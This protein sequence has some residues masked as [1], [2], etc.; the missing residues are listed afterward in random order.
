[1]LAYLAEELVRKGLFNDAMGV[2]I[3]HQLIDT[4]RPDVR[5]KLAGGVYK[6]Q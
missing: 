4:I 1:M 6:P 5:E 2:C 3:R